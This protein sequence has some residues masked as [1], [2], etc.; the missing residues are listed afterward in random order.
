MKPDLELT[1][2][3][4]VERVERLEKELKAERTMRIEFEE[5]TA[6]LTHRLVRNA[7]QVANILGKTE[8]LIAKPLKEDEKE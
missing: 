7:H 2:R 3:S 1:V 4:L 8:E 6:K 5:M